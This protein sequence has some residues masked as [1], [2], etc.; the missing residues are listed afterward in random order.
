M[1]RR[2][3]PVIDE[4]TLDY[5]AHR[6]P[7]RVATGDLAD[8]GLPGAIFTPS[9][10]HD[11]PVIALA[12]AWLQPV[13]RY[14]DTMRFLASWGFVVVAP[15]TER[16]LVPSYSGL[17]TDLSRA[18]RLGAHA[19]LGGGRVTVD[20]GKM[21]VLG[22]GSGGGAAVLAASRDDNIDAVVTVTAVDTKPSAAEAAGLCRMPSLHLIGT[23]GGDLVQAGGSQIARSWTGPTQ[24]RV[25][26][27]ASLLGF[28]E[29]KHWTSTVTGATSERKTQRIARMLAAA[30]FLR[31]LQGH[32]HLAEELEGA[33]SGT[34]LRDPVESAQDTESPSFT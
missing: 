17:G 29:G 28:A 23:D 11:L 15:D 1:A 19:R 32:D 13:S 2:R 9:S 14:L 33:V 20:P 18:L 10:G 25:I 26:K 31:H 27:R 12:H 22:H 8:G 6:G 5:L 24:L 7:H 4:P 3:R 30:F 16:G 21:G 34:E